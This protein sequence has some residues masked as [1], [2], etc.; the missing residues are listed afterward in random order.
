MY[1]P[2]LYRET[3]LPTLHGLMREYSF[4]TVVTQHD[5]APFATHTPI[6]L[7]AEEGPSGT[8]Y[9]HLARAN[10]QWQAF[11][12]GQEALVLFQGPHSYVSPSW[13]EVELSVPTWNYAA[14]HAYG[15]PR[16]VTEYA[17]FYQLLATLVRTY[18]G[19]FA[20]PWPFQLP[21]DYVRKMMQGI[22]GFSMPITRL[23][24]KYKLS[25]NR[26]LTDQHTVAAT[27]QQSRDPLSQ[28]VGRL[29]QQRQE[30][31]RRA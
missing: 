21:D 19:S 4:A 27:L 9:G 31:A 17:E 13:Y 6:V 22:V 26:S 16:L 23:E 20:K 30:A 2:P 7:A 29:M 5:G 18:E 12:A 14:V 25:Q 1:M 15:T 11:E 10:P 24:G 3:D 8:L 28:D